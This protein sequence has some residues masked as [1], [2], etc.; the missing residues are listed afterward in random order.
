MSKQKITKL[1]DATTCD[2]CNEEIDTQ[3]GDYCY[4]R[5]PQDDDHI[6]D[7]HKAK[8]TAFRFGWR[9]PAPNPANFDSY[10]RYDFHAAC[11]DNLMQKFLEKK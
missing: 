2:F 3:S 6:I 1:V 10:V 4:H 8:V 5:L 9:R 11:F 7:T